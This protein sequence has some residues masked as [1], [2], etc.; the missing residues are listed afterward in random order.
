MKHADNGSV[1]EVTLN[2]SFDHPQSFVSPGSLHIL[3]F[4]V[5]ML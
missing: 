3:A 4:F 5:P 1:E 2:S